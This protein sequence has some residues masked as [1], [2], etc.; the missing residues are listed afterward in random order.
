MPLEVICLEEKAFDEL[1]D[2]VVNRV[3][4]K[5]GSKENWPWI[6]EKEAMKRLKYTSKASLQKLRDND[7]IRI[8]QPTKKTI[9]YD[10]QSILDYIER[11]A[12]KRY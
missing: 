10:K 5:H 12:R 11:N 6:D 3:L 1:V 7:E 2:R 8:S 4:D 9:H